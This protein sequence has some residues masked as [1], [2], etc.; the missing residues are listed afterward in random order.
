LRERYAK[1]DMPRPLIEQF[2]NPPANPDRCVFARTTRVVSADLRSEVT[3]CQFGGNPDCSACGCMAS[4]GV[5]AIAAYKLAG[6]IPVGA[7]FEASVRLGKRI[8]GFSAQ[9]RALEDPLRIIQ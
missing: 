5:G 4:M 1:L 6:L 3:P 7:I 2:A 8:A 9:P